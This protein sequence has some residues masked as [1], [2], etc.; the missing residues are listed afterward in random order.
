MNDY[1]TKWMYRAGKVVE[2]MMDNNSLRRSFKLVSGGN[3]NVYA[4]FRGFDSYPHWGDGTFDETYDELFGWKQASMDRKSL[5]KAM[6][7]WGYNVISLER[8]DSMLPKDII[9]QINN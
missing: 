8:V 7:E 6:M 2:K 4:S 5:N 3:P 9:D 1:I